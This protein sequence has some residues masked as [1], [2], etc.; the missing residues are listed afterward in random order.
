M[1]F[2]GAARLRRVPVIFS[3]R[4]APPY[5]SRR[6][7]PAPSPRIFPCAPPLHPGSSPSSTVPARRD[8][9]VGGAR[10]GG[11]PSPRASPF[12]PVAASPRL[13]LASTAFLGLLAPLAPFLHEAACLRRRWSLLRA[14]APPRLQGRRRERAARGGRAGPRRRGAGLRGRAGPA[15]VLDAVA[16]H[17]ERRARALG[18]PL[19]KVDGLPTDD[20]WRELVAG[21]RRRRRGWAPRRSRT[22]AAPRGPSSIGP[23]RHPAGA[24]GRAH[25]V[26]AR[27]RAELAHADVDPTPSA[28]PRAHRCARDRGP[29]PP[30]REPRAASRS[31]AIS[32]AT[33]CGSGGRR[34][35]AIRG[36]C[37]GAGLDRL[38]ALEAWWSAAPR[39]AAGPGRPR[40]RSGRRRQRLLARIALSQRSWPRRRS[41]GS[42]SRRRREEL[43]R[44]GA[45]ALDAYG[46][47]VARPARR[48]PPPRDRRGGRAWPSPARSRRSCDPW[49]AARASE[50]FARP[51]RSSGPRRAA[52]RAVSRA[53]RRRRRAGR[54]LAALGAH[55]RRAARGRGACRACS[56]APISRSAPATSIARSSSAARRS[57]RRPDSFAALLTLG[58]A[59][60]ARGDLPT[61]SHWLGQGARRGARAPGARAARAWSRSRS[62]RSATW[63][64]TS[65]GRA[66]R[67]RAARRSRGAGR[68]ARRGSTRATCS[69]S[70][71]SPI[72]VARGR[73]STS[74][75]TRARRR[76]PAT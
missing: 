44:A 1:I 38:D 74:P 45:L 28:G 29:S 60:V 32:R 71:C 50:L 31:R 6:S 62:P 35:P 4:S 39:D 21:C 52:V 24:R 41:C 16:R 72:A 61:A 43:V 59:N 63:R 42:G 49:A 30:P 9:V 23:G 75:P 18:R 20:P 33:I 22:R 73:G 26:R 37:A 19:V 8:E 56:A 47:L 67:T 17:V 64:A 46:R 3:R 53:H 70:S 13:G 54:L 76:S 36:A 65:P 15:G 58:R 48:C 12:I 51:A 69:A 10:E 25:R 27:L 34:S 7:A 2:S 5:F 14:P 11:A 40:S 68:R 57:R 66:P 55:A